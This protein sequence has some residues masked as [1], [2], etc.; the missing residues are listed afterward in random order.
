MLVDGLGNMCQPGGT[1]FE[2]MDECEAW[3]CGMAR[4]SIG[5]GAVLLAL[6]GPGL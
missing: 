1:G 2:G 3:H 5:E 6:E 4:K